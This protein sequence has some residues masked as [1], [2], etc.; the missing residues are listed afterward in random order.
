VK[1]DAVA[2]VVA[3]GVV[4]L[5]IASQAPLF[6]DETYYWEWSRN[7]STGYFD[8]PPLVAWLIRLGTAVFGDSPLGVRAGPVLAGI[9][10]SLLIALTARRLAGD[11]AAVIAALVFAVMPLSAAGLVLA[12]PDAGLLAAAAGVIYAVVRALE[13]PPQSR[14]SLMWWCMAGAAQGIAF[15]SKYTAILVP[16]G[17][18][19]ALV[20][21]AEHRARLREAGP[22]VATLIASLVFSPVLLWNANND[23]VSFA[24]QIQHG[25][26]GSGGSILRRESELLGGQMGL[27]SPVLFFMMLVALVNALRGSTATATSRVLGV[28]SLF[29]LAFFTYSATQRRVEANWPALAYIPATLLLAAHARTPR[30]DRWLN[31][32]VAV[33]AVITLVTYI[34]TFVPIL[35]VAAPRDPAAR[36]SGWDDLARMVA[37][38]RDSLAES[39]VTGHESRVFIAGNRYQEASELAFH[40]PDRPRTLALNVDARPNHYDLWP[41]FEQRAS[42][43]DYLVLV[44]DDM[45]GLHPAAASLSPHFSLVTQGAPVSLARRGNVVKNLRIWVLSGWR[46]TWPEPP[47]RSRP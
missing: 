30:W 1:S 11:R 19:I 13:H 39:R 36:A 14:Q 29:V 41:G 8:H 32:G 5:A 6:P 16:A 25:L 23:W 17:L 9:I 45:A 35:P 44:V 33:A 2:V 26:V 18:A 20:L 4:R 15:W 24:F 40:L 43:G 46:G 12:T 34:N 28:A 21:F 27:V 10:G 38:V 31:A 7:L 3:A 42:R 37:R 47:L 22:Y